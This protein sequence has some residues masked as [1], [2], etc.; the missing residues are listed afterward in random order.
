MIMT[1]RHIVLLFTML[2]IVFSEGRAVGVGN[3]GSGES[4][5][6]LVNDLASENSDIFANNY[7]VPAIA[8]AYGADICISI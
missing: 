5:I 1:L 7:P 3:D 8:V 6:T 4:N 2:L